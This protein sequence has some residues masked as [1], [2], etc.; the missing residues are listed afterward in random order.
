MPAEHTARA[1]MR[2]ISFIAPTITC[3]VLAGL[4]GAVL[5]D[6]IEK[7][8]SNVRPVVNFGLTGATPAVQIYAGLSQRF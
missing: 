3:C 1:N 4:S 5:A 7:P 8:P 2:L 6:P